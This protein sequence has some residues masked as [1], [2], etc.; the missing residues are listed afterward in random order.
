MLSDNCNRKQGLRVEV[1]DLKQNVLLQ[2]KLAI[3]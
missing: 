1:L 3:L 2:I